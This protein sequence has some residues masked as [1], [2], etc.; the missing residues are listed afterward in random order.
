MWMQRHPHIERSW[1][2]QK[3]NKKKERKSY[4]PFLLA[5]LQAGFQFVGRLLVENKAIG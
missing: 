1:N 3:I 4:I 2:K 5:A